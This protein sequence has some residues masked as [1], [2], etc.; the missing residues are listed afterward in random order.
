[1]RKESETVTERASGGRSGD[2]LREEC[3]VFG[4]WGAP[5]AA[6]LTYA[7]LYALQHRGQESAG[8]V[9]TDGGEYR[10]HRGLGLVSDVFA[11]GAI[12][13]LAGH[14]AIGHN[15]YSTTG[16]SLLQNAQPLVVNFREGKLAIGHNGNLVNALE[17]RRE[18]EEQGSIFQTTS[19]TEVVLHLIARSKATEIE[20]MV[21]E[22][23]ARCQGAYS[24]VLLAGD[25]L[26]GV[27]DPRGFRP[28]CLGRRGEAHVLAS[29]TCA[30][31]IVG[32][33]F[34]RE[35]EPG[36]MVVIGA[37][38]VRSHRI[39]APEPGRACV[40]ELIYFSRPDSVVFGES[41]DSVRRRLGHRLAEEHPVPA[42]IVIS[43]PD[44]SNSAALGYAEQSRLP[45]E[46]G[47]IRNHYV[48]RTFIAP[49]QITRDFG[50]N[51]KFNPVRRILEGKRVVVVDDSIVRGTTSRSLV[52]ML[53]DAGAREIHLR[54]S[55]PPIGWSCYYGIDTPN[56]RELI[57]SS[58]TVE[59]IRKYLNVDSLGYL[60]MEG[61]RACVSRP[62]EHCYACFNGDY[63]VR[64]G[65]EMDKLALERGRVPEQRA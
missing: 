3:G 13:R 27:R 2:R 21:A 26:I 6:R 39:L 42:D 51:L 29:E 34:V 45:F 62:D 36:E 57:A 33:T 15:R 20:R 49:E 38:G 61:L 58:H 31:D 30:L 11:G 46:L 23:L 59:E 28:L 4:I 44:S 1:M 16:S 60:S 9:A 43:V 50:V 8:I 22:A 40:F 47:L 14:V 7:G 64:F 32:A 37:D 19:D 65:E 54:V 56:R 24:L 10:L 35:I 63:S 18:M 12:D 17:L 53:R 52:A 25:K 5:N 48:G 41:V 55:S